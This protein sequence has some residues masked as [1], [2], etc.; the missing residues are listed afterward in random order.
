MY[1][2]GIDLHKDMT[3]IT[4]I[5][6][7]GSVVKQSKLPNEE[8]AILNYFFSQGRNH[9]AVV[10]S[11]SNWYWLSDLLRNHQIEIILAHAKYLKAI[12]YAKVKTDKV[13][14][15]ILAQLLR[16]NLIPGAHQISTEKRG[17]RDLMRARLRLVHKKTSCLNSIHRLLEKFNFAVPNNRP[18]HELST[19]DL[20]TDLPFNS[21]YKFQLDILKEQ[22]VLLDR[23]IKA[24]EKSL[25]P[26]LIPNPEIQRLLYIPG[27]GKVLAFTIYLE[28]D[29]IERFPDVN[30]FYSYC[31]LV[32]G[33][34]NSNR[35][36]KHKSGNK[37]GNKYLKMAFTEAGFRAVQY[38][39]EIKQFYQSKARKKHKTIARNLVA[40]ELAKI[41]FY[42]LKD[43]VD[44]NNTFKGRKLSK[45][46]SKQWPRLT[47]PAA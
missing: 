13:D 28:V 36:L 10:E 11:T 8:Y 32:P 41:C 12:S 31:R 37:D 23:Q 7:S 3:F 2:S 40:K 39:K 25:H 46:K 17:L 33:S 15:L 35:K 29:G 4:T 21:E 22:V 27:I 44:F 9:K 6:D 18:M 20:L 26:L 5:D 42:L 45:E 38:Y 16:M 30:Q 43:K 24:L 14:S 19:L 34:D 1:Y 47:S